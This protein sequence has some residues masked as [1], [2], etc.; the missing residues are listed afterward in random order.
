MRHPSKNFGG[1]WCLPGGK[2]EHGE[3][4]KTTAKRELFEETSIVVPEENLLFLD[5]FYLRYPRLD[6]IYHFYSCKLDSLPEKIALA[7]D[8][9]TDF[10]WKKLHP[11]DA[12]TLIAGEKA[13]LT[14]LTPKLLF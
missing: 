2:I 13:C 6:F 5:T 3:E 11:I 12:H 14:H 10:E 1:Q 8:E 9:H 7:T 4:H